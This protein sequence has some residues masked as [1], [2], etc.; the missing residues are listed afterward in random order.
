[1]LVDLEPASIHLAQV[2]SLKQFH[3]TGGMESGSGSGTGSGDR[4]LGKALFR[5]NRLRL[6]KIW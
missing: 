5:C 4:I 3:Y 2:Y 6:L 1:M